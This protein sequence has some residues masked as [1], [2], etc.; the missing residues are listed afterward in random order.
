MLHIE[1]GNRSFDFEEPAPDKAST[2]ESSNSLSARGARALSSL[3]KRSIDICV[4]TL[5]LVVLLPVFV[6]IAIAVRSTS[7]GPVFFCQRRYGAKRT[8]F[9]I[10]KFRTMTV[11]ESD[12]RFQQAIPSDPR[13]TPVGRV[14]RKYSLDELPQLINVLLGHMSLVGPRPH[15]LAMDNEF[16][17][18]IPD[19]D[20]RF[21]VRPGMTGLAQ[22]MG[23]RGPTVTNEDIS[24]RLQADRNYISQWSI[25]L[26]LKILA[27]TPLALLK[28]DA[29]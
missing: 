25:L 15:A 27:L 16:L 20:D 2:I 21:L 6:V 12:G 3:A 14:L 13:V 29:F 10:F 18:S 11:M 9:S 19:Y 24:K 4:A 23:Y 26:D 28:Q 7:A 5:A 8:A 22:I 17:S 1:A